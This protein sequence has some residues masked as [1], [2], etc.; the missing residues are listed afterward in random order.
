MNTRLT[1]AENNISS[2]SQL[3][4]TVQSTLAGK[5]DAS[6]VQALQTQVTQI[7]NEVTSNSTAIT[8]VRA[9]SGTRPN[10]LANGDFSAELPDGRCR[11]EWAPMMFRSGV[12]SRASPRAPRST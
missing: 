10:L 4:S 2:L 6:A 12:Y 9:L 11:R 3:I 7:G 1:Q 5:A 8:Q